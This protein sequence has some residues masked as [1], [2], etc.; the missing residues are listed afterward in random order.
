MS[1]LIL[2]FSE[3][4]P[5]PVS[6]YISKEI[7]DRTVAGKL[8]SRPDIIVVTDATYKR[9]KKEVSKMLSSPYHMLGEITFRG[10]KII[11]KEDYE[12]KD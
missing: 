5:S 3:D 10:I 2:M 1:Q 4:I 11:K 8:S 12:P 6:K 9:L 7:D